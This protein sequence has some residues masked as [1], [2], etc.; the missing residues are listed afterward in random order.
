MGDGVFYRV[1]IDPLLV[2]PHKAAVAAIE[3]G[4]NI[5]DIACG[6][7]TLPLMYANKAS[8]VTGIDIDQESVLYAQSRVKEE[9]R[10]RIQFRVM[11]ASDLGEFKDRQFTHSSV[12]MAMHQFSRE[13][14]LTVLE[15]MKRISDRIILV[16][17]TFPLNK[18]FS[19]GVV[20]LIEKMAGAEHHAHF[21]D[22]LKHGGMRGL[23]DPL[24]LKPERIHIDTN[25][26][27]VMEILS[28]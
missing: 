14:A 10:D 12:S 18:A 26:F 13:T 17:Y 1:V 23:L 7:G 15:Q 22:Y 3:E 6:N 11:D 19:G 5:L 4:A 25:V 24:Q 20:R 28:D 8:V 27:T 21:K 16:D 2:R 9:D